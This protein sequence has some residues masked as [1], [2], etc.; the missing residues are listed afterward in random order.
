MFS[1]IMLLFCLISCVGAL[2]GLVKPN[3][4]KGNTNGR[5]KTFCRFAATG[6]VF[7]FL[8]SQTWFGPLA[9]VV[10]TK[11]AATAPA[12]DTITYIP[13]DERAF[14]AAIEKA[15]ADYKAA[16]NEMAAGGFRVTRGRA[17][18]A[19]LPA[20]RMAASNWI[21]KV[22]TLTSN[23]DGN[24]VIEIALADGITVGTYNN[25]LSDFATHTLIRTT[26]PLFAAASSRSVGEV[27]TFS[28]DLFPD[29]TDCVKEM[30]LT[31]HGSMTAPE[32]LGLFTAIAP[33]S[34]PAKAQIPEP[35]PREAVAAAD[36]TLPNCDTADKASLTQLVL[37]SP[38][39]NAPGAEISDMHIQA[40]DDHSGHKYC[41]VIFRLNHMFP[42][43]MRYYFGRDKTGVLDIYGYY[44]E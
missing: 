31:L 4:I 34:P 40:D 3:L 20:D 38:K 42:G 17:I 29:D 6:A 12:P 18:C 41:T 43:R 8:S 37:Q 1:G 2:I 16:A 26:S 23:R 14:I 33:F 11:L 44:V 36:T 15:R 10:S 9:W 39:W 7:L 30:S 32:F 5:L 24:G 27:V 13:Q 35:S 28:A 21:G 19:A 25:S 22:K